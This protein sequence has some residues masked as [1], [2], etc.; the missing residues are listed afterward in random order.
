MTTP[1]YLAKLKRDTTGVV[2][3]IASN[4]SVA[5]VKLSPTHVDWI[6]QWCEVSCSSSIVI[7]KATDAEA[8]EAQRELD[9]RSGGSAT[10]S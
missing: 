8:A 10:L 5:A 3:G 2:K 7:R 1:T 6:N 4:G 9:E